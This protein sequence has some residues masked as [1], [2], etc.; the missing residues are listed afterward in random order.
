MAFKMIYDTRNRTNLSK[1][2][3]NTK[4]AAFK[5]YQYCIDNR[6]QILIYET[7]RTLEAQ[8]QNVAKGAS[9]TLKSY[10]LVGQALDFVPVDSKGNATWSIN[11]Y[12]RK[13]IM[14]AIKYAKALEFTWG[15]DWDNDGDWRDETFLDSP[16]LQFNFKGYGTDTFGKLKVD[17]I[18]NEEDDTM[19]F[20]SN[21]TKNAIRDELS[22]YV[23]KDYIDKSWIT[24]FDNGTMTNGDYL[25]LKLIAEQ[26]KNSKASHKFG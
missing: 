5:W 18:S 16:H 25:A 9:K 21:T 26:R 2:A 7:I 1:L 23:E 3:D 24:K 13:D 12:I 11:N 15:G 19:K 10:Y 17:V 14:S 8:K 4:N 20:S 6:I 22:Q